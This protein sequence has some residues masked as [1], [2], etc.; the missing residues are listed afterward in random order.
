MNQK[1]WYSAGVAVPAIT[2]LLLL[3][4]LN[5]V[6]KVDTST[7]LFSTGITPGIVFG[8][9]NAVIAIAIYKHRI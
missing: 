5:A 3:G 6:L 8:I 1:M 2:A 4:I 7:N 9:L